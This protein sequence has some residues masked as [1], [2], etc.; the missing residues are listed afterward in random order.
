MQRVDVHWPEVLF[1]RKWKQIPWVSVSLGDASSSWVRAYG[2][3]EEIL[4][5]THPQRGNA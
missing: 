1:L 5:Q 2:V 3:D 4:H